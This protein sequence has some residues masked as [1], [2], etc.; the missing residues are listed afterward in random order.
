[1]LISCI[2][3]Y[4]SSCFR[5]DTTFHAK[6]LEVFIRIHLFRCC[7]LVSFGCPSWV[8]F[9]VCEMWH[10]E[11]M[12]VAILAL[13]SFFYRIFLYSAMQV[14]KVFIFLFFYYY[15]WWTWDG[16]CIIYWYSIHYLLT[17]WGLTIWRTG[18]CGLYSRW[19]VAIKR[20]A[21]LYFLPT[22][23]KRPIFYLYTNPNE[24]C[25]VQIWF[26]LSFSNRISPFYNLINQFC[27]C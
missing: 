17:E 2:F 10:I 7:V 9:W 26:V 14:N 11:Y 1:M 20:G 18:T 16:V 15:K 3:F 25:Y 13:W 19:I 27:R 24:K 23:H 6:K 21:E 8:F 5:K 12:P 22:A 4:F